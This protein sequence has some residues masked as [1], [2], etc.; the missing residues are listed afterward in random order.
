VAPVPGRRARLTEDEGCALLKARFE[1]AG[2]SI[3]EHH[4]FQELGLELTLDGF[5][6]ERRV[7]YEYV[8]T[9]AGDRE[10]FTPEVLTRLEDA[11]RAGE[12]TLLL[13]DEA[14]V[15]ARA[16]DL[17]AGRFLRRVRAAP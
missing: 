8:T 11:L 14:Q 6:V 4:P 17:A 16:L 15:D 10:E 2:F 3:T 9:E 7:G 1:A 5:D 13:V 12:L